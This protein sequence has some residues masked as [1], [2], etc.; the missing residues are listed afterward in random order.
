MKEPFG[1]IVGVA[2][3]LLYPRT[4]VVGIINGFDREPEGPLQEKPVFMNKEGK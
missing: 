4:F 2:R 3:P 1:S